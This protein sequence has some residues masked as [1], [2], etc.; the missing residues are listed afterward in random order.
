MARHGSDYFKNPVGTGPFRL[1]EWRKDERI[2]LERNSDYWGPQPQLDRLIF[3]PI[4]ESSVRFLS[5]RRA[6]FTAFR[7]PQS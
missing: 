5:F 6:R 3:K 2:V 1:V 4:Q 7:Q